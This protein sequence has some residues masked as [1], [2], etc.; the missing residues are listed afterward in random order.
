M[1]C[2]PQRPGTGNTSMCQGAGDGLRGDGIAGGTFWS[3]GLGILRDQAGDDSYEASVFAQAT[4]YWSGIGLLSDGAG[5][6]RYEAI[7]YVQAGAA[8]YSTAILVD[9]GAGDDVF[10]DNEWTVGV[11]QGSGHDFSL[12]MLIDEGGND[13]YYASGNGAATGNCNGIGV[14]VDNGGND[15]YRANTTWSYGHAHVSDECI[16]RNEA[17][18]EAVFLDVG[19]DDTYTRDGETY[20][21]GDDVS[22]IQRIDYSYRAEPAYQTYTDGFPTEHGVGLDAPDGDSTLHAP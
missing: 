5:A 14:F 13:R 9:S 6:D 15:E 20:V 16:A 19:G 7:W 17:I 18:T 2:S 12:G 22:W 21:L 10:N 4:A 3:G 8:H 1:Y 11:G